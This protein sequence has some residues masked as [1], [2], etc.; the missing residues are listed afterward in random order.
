M[1]V[2]HR[3]ELKEDWTLLREEKALKKIDPLV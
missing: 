2:N 1:G 3:E